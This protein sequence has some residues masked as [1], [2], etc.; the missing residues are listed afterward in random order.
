[1][2][3]AREGA[4]NE[5]ERVAPTTAARS[6]ALSLSRSLAL[7]LSR[8]LALSLLT[9]APRSLL[10]TRVIVFAAGEQELQLRPGYL[11]PDHPQT[12]RTHCDVAL[13][14]GALLSND[15][16]ALLR[17]FPELGGAAGA[18]KLRRDSERQHER[19]RA[20]YAR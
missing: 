10:R 20:L 13:A 2:C 12:G 9:L 4:R 1:M 5:G 8:S 7:S 15:K 14:L 19:I 16:R 6:L 18:E 11:G 17:E 3:A